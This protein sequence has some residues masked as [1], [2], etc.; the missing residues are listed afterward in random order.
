[1]AFASLAAGGLAL[2]PVA[3]TGCATGFGDVPPAARIVGALHRHTTVWVIG[4]PPPQGLGAGREGAPALVVLESG[5]QR[6]PGPAGVFTSS[7]FECDPFTEALV[8]W[9]AEVPDGWGV[10][11]DARF[12]DATTGQWGAW[13]YFGQAGD[14]RGVETVGPLVQTFDGGTV[15]VDVL[16]SERTM[17]ALEVRASA[18]RGAVGPWLGADGG[19]QLS[20]LTVVTTAA[21]SGTDDSALVRLVPGPEH[22]RGLAVELAVPF[23]SQKTERPEIA[24]RICSPTSVAMLLAHFGVGVPVGRVA[25]EAFDPRAE[26]Y[27]NWPANTQAAFALARRAGVPIGAEVRRFSSWDEVERAVESGHPMALSIAVD[28]GELPE[29][30]Y[31]ST[32]GHLIVLRGFDG[33]GDLLVNDPACGDAQSGQRVYPRAAMTTIWLGR[34]RGTAY[35]L[36]RCAGEFERGA[37]VGGR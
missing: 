34:C 35:V 10:R 25:E 16:R 3:L 21:D 8:S 19:V 22:R 12:R 7:A 28:P 15:E 20:R 26:I 29:A 23:R 14:S 32:D 33:R 18:W 30:P 6:A 17:N 2:S 1:M 27:G 36:W 4:T 9:N 24:G 37:R 31:P 11:F 13:L 5:E